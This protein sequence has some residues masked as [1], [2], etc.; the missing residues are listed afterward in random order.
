[1]LK[2][3]GVWGPSH[4]LFKT[5]L[6]TFLKPYSGKRHGRALWRRERTKRHPPSPRP[7]PIW[8]GCKQKVAETANFFS[9]LVSRDD[10][11]EFLSAY[12]SAIASTA[13]KTLSSSKSILVIVYRLFRRSQR[14]YYLFLK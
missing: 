7:L 4:H 14:W 6:V 1:M 2:H 9:V 10:A 3:R 12:S 11:M 5:T 8:R 13:C